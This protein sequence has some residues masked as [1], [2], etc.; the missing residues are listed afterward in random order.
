MSKFDDFLDSFERG[1]DAQSQ[2]EKKTG[3]IYKDMLDKMYDWLYSHKGKSGFQVSA[4]GMIECGQESLSEIHAILP[5]AKVR[6][7]P[8]VKGMPTVPTSILTNDQEYEKRIEYQDGKWKAGPA[9]IDQEW[10]E[11][12]VIEALKSAR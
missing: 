9:Y 10:F 12:F 3:P 7:F 4:S 8:V 5:K 6:V 1:E 11:N 2:W